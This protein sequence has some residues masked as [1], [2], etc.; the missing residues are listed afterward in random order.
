MTPAARTLRSLGTRG[1]VATLR[2]ARRRLVI[3]ASRRRDRRFDR[4]HGTETRV[5]VEN[6]ALGDVTSPNL[7]RGIRYEPT[8]AL[9][10][11]RLL[12]AAAIPA[13]GTFVDVGCGKGRVLMLA[14]M[15]GFERVTGVDYSPSLC[16]AARHNLEA[17]HA[18]E[19]LR[20]DATIHAMDAVDYAFQPGDT[21]V[22]LYNPFDDV[23]LRRVLENL[24]A[25]LAAHPRTLRVIYHKPVWRSVIGESGLFEEAD[26]YSFGG[27]EFAVYRTR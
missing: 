21:V 24:R 26:D 22:F 9:P 3:W 13:R 8:R 19:G 10:L 27:C 2:A 15:H 6:E 23:V 18:A 11:E 14:A 20:F 4:R 7:A 25:S 5:V 16:A 17:L 12:R 1:L